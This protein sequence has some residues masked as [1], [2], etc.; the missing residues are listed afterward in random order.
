MEPSA[1]ISQL[2]GTIY[3]NCV[4]LRNLLQ[5]HNSSEPIYNNLQFLETFAIISHTFRFH[6]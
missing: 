2:L 4:T 1:I 6:F 5:Y 3:N